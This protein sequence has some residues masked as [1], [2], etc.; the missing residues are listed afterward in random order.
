MVLL[1]V[2]YLRYLCKQLNGCYQVYWK[3]LMDIPEGSAFLYGYLQIVVS[4]VM[5]CLWAYDDGKSNQ[6]VC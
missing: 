2:V 3:I 6:V 4:S 1:L 5:L